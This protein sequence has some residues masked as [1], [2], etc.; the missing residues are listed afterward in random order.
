MDARG[1]LTN[2]LA[3]AQPVL[4]AAGRQY[5]ELLL[6]RRS[7]LRCGGLTRGR[8]VGGGLGCCIRWLHWGPGCVAAPPDSS[9]GSTEGTTALPVSSSARRSVT[10][11]DSR[12]AGFC[13]AGEL[14]PAIVVGHFRQMGEIRAELAKLSGSGSSVDHVAVH[15]IGPGEIQVG[16]RRGDRFLSGQRCFL[17]GQVD[18]KRPSSRHRRRSPLWSGRLECP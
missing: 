8:C 7:G 16:S 5:V 13:P 2:S 1:E 10:A 9:G 11:N 15:R 3:A 17:R 18:L 6:P 14:I 4:E 12:C